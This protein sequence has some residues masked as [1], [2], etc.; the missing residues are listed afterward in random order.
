MGKIPTFLLTT[1]GLMNYAS[2]CQWEIF[3]RNF[4][5]VATSQAHA[6]PETVFSNFVIQTF[7]PSL[8]RHCLH[9]SDPTPVTTEALYLLPLR[10]D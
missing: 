8:V 4:R 9:E 6:N 3:P 5:S 1:P 7:R 2:Y 10:L